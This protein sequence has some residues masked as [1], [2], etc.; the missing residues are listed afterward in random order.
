MPR[1]LLRLALVAALVVPPTMTSALDGG[2]IDTVFAI[3][4]STSRNRVDYGLRLDDACRPRGD[5]PVVAY[6]RRLARGPNVTGGIE[7]LER[8]AYGVRHQRV[9]RRDAGGEVAIRLRAF[10]RPI[11]IVA[12]RE[13]DRCVAHPYTRVAGQRAELT[14][15]FVVLEGPRSVDH[16]RVTGR[17]PGGSTVHETIRP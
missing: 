7:G 3:R 9:T 11:E 1:T 16:V 5:E 2:G 6:H 4:R 14:D 13:G 17:T 10:E 15:V 8:L 12:A